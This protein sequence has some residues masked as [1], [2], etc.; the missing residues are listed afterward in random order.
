VRLKALV[1]CATKT[2]VIVGRVRLLW[3]GQ[4]PCTGAEKSKTDAKLTSNCQSQYWRSR[5]KN[6]GHDEACIYNIFTP[7]ARY[8]TSTSA[9]DLE[10]SVLYARRPR[11]CAKLCGGSQ[12]SGTEV[13]D[14]VIRCM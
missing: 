1:G 7:Y 6:S 10:K 11:C 9:P 5:V 8:S 12:S 3:I 13:G 2:E 4:A 14:S